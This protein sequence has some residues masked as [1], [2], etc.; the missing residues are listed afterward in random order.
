MSI[1]QPGTEQPDNTQ[2]PDRRELRHQIREQRRAERRELTGGT[3]WIAGA[4]L[5]VLGVALLMQNY[6]L[7][8]LRNWWALFILIPAVGSFTAA[9][10]IFRNN[11]GRFTPVGI[12]PLIGGLILI[13]LTATFLFDLSWGIVGPILLILIGIGALLGTVLRQ[14]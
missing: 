9:W 6:G 11:G 2:P 8:A 13:A 5:V 12:G 10:A 1:S 14:G 3:G 7:F 4:I